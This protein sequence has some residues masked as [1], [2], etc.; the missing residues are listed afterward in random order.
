M[1][2]FFPTSIL[3]KTLE[4]SDD[5]AHQVVNQDTPFYMCDFQCTTNPVLVGYGGVFAFIINVGDTW[6][7]EHANL[8]D[9]MVM[10][11]TAG[12]NGVLTVI[13]S[14]PNKQVQKELG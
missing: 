1:S 5:K 11:Q 12:N 14:V 2:T 7:T 6:T 10:N 4:L 9:I 13:A 8:R 3:V